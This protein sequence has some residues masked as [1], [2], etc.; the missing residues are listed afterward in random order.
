MIKL[1]Y[2]KINAKCFFFCKKNSYS[3]WR[4][5]LF[6]FSGE[7]Y[8]FDIFSLT[9]LSKIFYEKFFVSRSKKPVL[10]HLFGIFLL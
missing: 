8:M 5:Y 2:K 9:I 7:M 6:I 3:K 1:Y 10:R 4:I